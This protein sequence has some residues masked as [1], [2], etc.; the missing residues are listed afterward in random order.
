[1]KS[2]RIYFT[3]DVHGYVY[4]TDYLDNDRKDIGLLNCMNHYQKDGNTLIIDGGD[5]IQG[6]PFTNYLSSKP[7][8]KHPMADIMNVARYD[9][10][11][12]GNH[13]FNYGYEYLKSYINHL[14][15]KCLC[16]NIKDTTGGIDILP[17]DIKVMENG[18]KV[19]V[20]GFTTDFITR[21]ERPCNIENF[22]IEDVYTSIENCFNIVKEQV[23]IV[24]GIYHGGFEHE[25]TT[26]KKLSESK[27][28]IAYKICKNF[29]F[30]ILLTGHQHMPIDGQYL[31][32]T[33]IV[34][35]PH[36]GTR[37]IQLT[38][39]YDEETG[40]KNFESSLKVASLPPKQDVYDKY[41]S[42]EDEVQRWL[43][44]PVGHLSQELNPED[45]LTMA[46]QGSFLANFINQI[47]LEESGAD[48]ACTSFA[49]VIKGFHK[50]VT[51]RDI[52][53]TYPYPNTLVVLKVSK[54]VLK[55]ALE[56]CA[57][58]FDYKDGEISI[59]ESFLK[60]KVEHYNYDYFSNLTYTFDL[61][62][63]VGNRVTSISY[64]GKELTNEDTLSLVMNN[65][66]SSGAGGYEFYCECQVEKEI[67]TE[68][69]ELIINYFTKNS[70]VDVDEN[71][72]IHVIPS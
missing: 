47:Q 48:I 67:L 34:Q 20:I 9:Y 18:L 33:Y 10:V 42:L 70:F 37:F 45:H 66:R 24:I 69:P 32:G 59:S 71:T 31:H 46:R 72:Y 26:N 51:V 3:S 6:S 50:N 57:S 38:M 16:T 64:Q 35:T 68:M 55:K 30:D 41:L 58:Y 53:A 25:L 65:Y 14:D 4:P 62:N 21:W 54:D 27:E 49:N 12:F 22:L 11:T 19:G 13:E 36:N 7:L 15:G 60:P 56:R 23:D 29:D 8:N 2:L 5:T 1:M 43:D 39:N 28:N 17:Y 63:E 44:T 40:E 61:K 52:L